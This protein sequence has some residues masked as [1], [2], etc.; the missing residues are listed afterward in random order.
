M[1]IGEKIKEL[2]EAKGWSQN[3][4]AE[5]LSTHKNSIGGWEKDAN[6]P[7]LFNCILLAD[8]FGITLD[9]LCGRGDCNAKSI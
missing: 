8:L 6:E 3:Q 2:R 7:S 5:L 1:T 9:E 4:L